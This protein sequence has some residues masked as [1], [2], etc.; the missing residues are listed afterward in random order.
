MTSSKIVLNGTPTG[1]LKQSVIH[2]MNPSNSS[3][4]KCCSI[5]LKKSFI[6]MRASRVKIEE[7]KITHFDMIF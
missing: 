3:I 4:I 2:R 7:D 6:N 5:F 1:Q